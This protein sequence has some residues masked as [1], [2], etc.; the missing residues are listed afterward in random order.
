M[1]AYPY[2]ITPDNVKSA[3][4]SATMGYPRD[5]VALFDRMI[6]ADPMFAG[7]YATRKNAAIGMD[8]QVVP[9]PRRTTEETQSQAEDIAKWCYHQIVNSEEFDKF[10]HHNLDAIG[11]GIAVSE[12]VWTVRDGRHTIAEVC[13]VPMASLI[14]DNI[15]PWVVRVLTNE[16]DSTGVLVDDHPFKFVKR[17]F[18]EINGNPFRGG[19]ARRC[20]LLHL[21]KTYGFRWWMSAMEMFGVPYRKATYTQAATAEEKNEMLAQLE[22][23]GHAGYGLFSEAMN[24]EFVDQFKGAESWPHTK[25]IDKIHE[26]YE[27]TAL[28]QTLTTQV[29]ETGG[30]YATAKVHN[31]VRSDILYR[32]LADEAATI[33]RHILK[34]LVE[35]NFGPGAPIPVWQRIEDDTNDMVAYSQVLDTAVNRLGIKVPVGFAYKELG[36]PIPDG[37]NPADVLEGAPSS[38]SPFD[39]FALRAAAAPTP[40]FSKKKVVR[41]R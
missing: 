32:D 1:A 38:A 10:L 23:F 39:S 28:G 24:F 36:V 19:V 3:L 18:G 11:Y 16:T 13:P 34:P 25:V 14:G 15:R 33:R 2:D 29:G 27:I 37:V 40:V 7:V 17:T 22:A 8:W 26:W 12:I 31:E 5:Q 9:D 6:E 20:A 21:A 30:A 41:R 4:Q 35:L